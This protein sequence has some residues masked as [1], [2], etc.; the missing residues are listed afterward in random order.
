MGIESQ[1]LSCV[2]EDGRTCK[3]VSKLLAAEGQPLE[4]PLLICLPPGGF[5]AGKGEETWLLA[6]ETALHFFAE[7]T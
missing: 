2:H 7:H 3:T 4:E 1:K 5:P 6:V